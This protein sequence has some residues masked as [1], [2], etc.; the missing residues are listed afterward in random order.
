MQCKQQANAYDKPEGCDG[1][2]KSEA[3]EEKQ[4]FIEI[5]LIIKIKEVQTQNIASKNHQ[6]IT[7]RKIMIKFVPGIIHNTCP[8]KR[9]CL[10]D[11]KSVILNTV[12]QIIHYK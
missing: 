11:F 1:E 12:D 5:K 7:Q 8:S 10:S 6:C 3:S 9:T 2:K 4:H